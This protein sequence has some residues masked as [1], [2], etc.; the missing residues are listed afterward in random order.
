MPPHDFPH[1]WAFGTLMER[2]AMLQADGGAGGSHCSLHAL[3]TQRLSTHIEQANGVLRA[4][5]TVCDPCKSGEFQD[6]PGQTSCK[7][8]AKGTSSVPAS[9]GC[10]LCPFGG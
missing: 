8:C 2:S 10:D 9:T 5:A 3:R 6:T 7:L 4:G 1:M